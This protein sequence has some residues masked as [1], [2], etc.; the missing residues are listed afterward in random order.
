MTSSPMRPSPRVAARVQL[1]VA[2]HQRE[3]H[4]VDLELAEVVR[5]GSDLT[6]DAAGPRSE[7][8][9]G[10]GVV[11]AEHPLQMLSGGELGG[12]AGSADQLRGRVGRAQ[13]GVSVL[14][15]LQ[16]TQQRV[17]F[18]VGDDR[19]VLDVVAELV[20]TDLIGELL[21]ASAQGGLGRILGLFGQRRFGFAGCL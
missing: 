12:E 16:F 19:R 14:E 2:V 10:E 7:F 1:P 20:I 3:S 18:R 13:L 15:R 11:Q 6:L 5:V 21:P 4:T 8:L 9:W 17:E